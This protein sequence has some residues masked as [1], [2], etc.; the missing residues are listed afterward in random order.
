MLIALCEKL[1]VK[2]S[3]RREVLRRSGKC[4]F[5]IF[6]TVAVKGDAPV[7][8]QAWVVSN[9]RDFILITHTCTEE[10][11]PEEIAEANEIALMTGLG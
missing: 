5:G 7:Y 4:N 2:V 6:G 9:Q 11:E 3:N 8:F 1:T 10:P